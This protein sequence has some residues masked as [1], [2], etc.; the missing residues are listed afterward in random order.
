MTVDQFFVGREE[1]HR[2]FAALRA[3]IDACGPAEVRVTKSQISFRRGR[4]FA[5][6]WTPDRY[7]H[8]AHAPLVLTLSFSRRNDSPRWKEIVEPTPGRFTHH[9]ELYTEADIDSEVR[10]WLEEAWYSA[11]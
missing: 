1:S 8:S 4:A 9:L 3:A 10:C 2:I 7:L 11:V 6:A 5:W